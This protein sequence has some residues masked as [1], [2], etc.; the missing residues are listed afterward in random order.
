M[1]NKIFFLCMTTLMLVACEK[2]QPQISE[3]RYDI[4]SNWIVNAEGSETKDVDLFFLIPTSWTSTDADGLYCEIDNASLREKAPAVVSGAATAFA[5]SCNLYAP[6][7]RQLNLAFLENLK[8]EKLYEAI[9]D[10]PY[11]DALSAFKYY[12]EHY[13]NGRPF[14]LAS[15]SQG[16][17]VATVMLRKFF[18]D[19][20]DIQKRMVA[21]YLIG[22]TIN[23]QDTVTYKNMHEARSATDLGTIICWNVETAEATGESPVA[24]GNGMCINPINWRTDDTYAPASESKGSYLKENGTYIRKEHFADARIN[25]SRG[26]VIISTV[27]STYLDGRPVF[28][29]G[30]LH[31]LD[32]PLY[33]Y[34]I[35]Q[36]AADRIAAWKQK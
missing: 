3:I 34:D 5:N 6:Y 11:G 28:P 7:Y 27:P 13:N 1:N 25:T 26:T 33:Y 31:N 23:R 15:H 10:K 29:L 24:T 36:N 35:A 18:H 20:P 4:P 32:Y 19:N 8:G 12:L 2:E 22:Y 14:I 9:G 17:Q 21:A 30:C 16:T